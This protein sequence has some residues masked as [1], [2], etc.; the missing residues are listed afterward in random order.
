MLDVSRWGRFQDA[1][2]AAHYEF[3][4]KKAG[5]KVVYCAEEFSNQDSLADYFAKI[6]KR[7][8]AAEYSR[9]LSIKS[10]ENQKRI[11]QL[12]FRVGSQ[13]GYGFRRAAVGADG[14][15][16]G[17]LMPGETKAL[18]SDRVTL[19]QGPKKEVQC[20]RMIFRMCL[21]GKS[22]NEI[23][24]ELN[25]RS[26]KNAGRKWK[27]WMIE[28]ILTNSKY[29]GIYVWNRRTQRLH[30]RSA[31]NRRE[32][33]IVK[34][35]A[36]PPI[37]S[38]AV[39]EKAQVRMHRGNHWSDEQ[40][41][42]KLKRLLES[43]GYLSERLIQNTRGMPSTATYWKRLGTFRKIY[44]SVGFAPGDRFNRSDS[45]QRTQGLRQ[46]L[47]RQIQA[48]FPGRVGVFRLKGKTRELM[49]LDGHDLSILLC[50]SVCRPG[51]A[52]SWS[53]IPVS[54]ES[55]YLTLVCRLNS[56]NDAFHSFH[57]FRNICKVKQI[58]FTERYRWLLQGERVNSLEQL[59]RLVDR[60]SR[61]SASRS[62][63]TEDVVHE[64]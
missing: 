40:L 20:V 25:D 38:E 47:I 36:F 48:L 49:R 31:S 8:S 4:C 33:W 35:H 51:R 53:L 26:M 30:S 60:L 39:F 14:S 63:R 62:W 19:V 61:P 57:L 46:G 50:P 11:V 54:W 22:H 24:R 13:P 29:A 37:I 52:L 44:A 1:D 27:N 16:K 32:A 23:A 59:A 42:D 43:K 7:T 17:I 34:R 56:A 3:V 64:F 45:R 12:G 2:E 55:R 9:E 5:I 15:C 18:M 10:F 58:K 21:R 41:L 6:L 28:D